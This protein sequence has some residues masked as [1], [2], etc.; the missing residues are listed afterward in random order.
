MEV[1][2]HAKYRKQWEESEYTAGKPIPGYFYRVVLYPKV[3]LSLHDRGN[4]HSLTDIQLVA[5]LFLRL[6]CSPT[7]EAV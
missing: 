1:D 7:N 5:L 4:Y 6:V 3:V 2:P